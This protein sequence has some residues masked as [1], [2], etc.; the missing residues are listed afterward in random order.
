MKREHG[1]AA[2]LLVSMLAAG[3]VVHKTAAESRVGL[4]AP[5]EIWADA[6][7][8]TSALSQTPVEQEQRLGARLAAT[9]SVTTPQDPALQPY[10]DRVGAKVAA[11]ARRKEIQY[12][13]TVREDPT[14]NAFALPGGHIFVNTGL[15]GF[16]QSEDELAVVLGHEIS[17]IELR[18]TTPNL[19][20]TVLSLGYTKYQEFDADDAGVRLAASAGYNPRAAITLFRN[21]DALHPSRSSVRQASTPFGEAGEVLMETLGTYWHSHPETEE[22]IRRVSHTIERSH[23]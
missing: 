6:L 9:I 23:I 8:D 18:H 7:R 19:I 10:V 15:L 5:L 2:A 16:V 14:I 13:F 3:I 1:L 20:R 21:L 12:R 4:S 11:T 17:H 22:R